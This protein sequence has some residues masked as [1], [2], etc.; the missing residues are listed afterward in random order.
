MYEIAICDDDVEFSVGFRSMLS[1]ILDER[2]AAYRVA[3]FSDP[4][5]LMRS[6][7]SGVRYNLLF[8]DVLFDTE[9]GIRLAKD[10]RLQKQDM[11]IVFVTNAAQY[12]IEGYAVYPLNYLLKP[13]SREKLSE[14]VDH[15]L[16]KQAQQY[17]SLQTARGQVQ[18]QLSDVLY[19]EVFNHEIIVHLTDKSCVSYKGTL[20]ELELSLPAHLFARCHRCYL[21]N[22]EH[23]RRVS[24]DQMLFSTGETVPISKR[25]Y[26]QTMHRLN[27]YADRNSLLFHQG[28]H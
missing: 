14:I 20:R 24:H 19:F 15:F 4:S 9:R 16:E 6:I 17:V 8:Q 12:A 22:L 28:G 5:E 23:V 10:L 3:L 25:L 11:D 26:T 18:I 13:V 2:N 27:E 1:A 21:V 7:E